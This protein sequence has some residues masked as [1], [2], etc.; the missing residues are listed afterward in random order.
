MLTLQA[1]RTLL[2][3]MHDE[4]QDGSSTQWERLTWESQR[5]QQRFRHNAGK[6]Q[7]LDGKCGRKSGEKWRAAKSVAAITRVA[8][9]KVH[10][11]TSVKR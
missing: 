6:K 2:E 7:G 11:L 9:E 8:R 3:C 10:P 4:S 5:E 1:D